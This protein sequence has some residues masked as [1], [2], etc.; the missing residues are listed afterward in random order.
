M[1]IRWQ[2]KKKDSLKLNSEQFM[3]NK[4]KILDVFNISY[5][6]L[7]FFPAN[8]YAAEYAP[9]RGHKL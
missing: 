6:C 8:L 2:K 5:I 7:H 3:T 1:G 4:V 9:L